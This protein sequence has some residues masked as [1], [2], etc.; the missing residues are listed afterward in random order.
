LPERRIVAQAAVLWLVSRALL[1]L[2]WWVA[3]AFGLVLPNGQT[4]PLSPEVTNAHSS[5]LPWLHWDAVWYVTIA[6]RGYDFQS[7]LAPGGQPVVLPGFFPLYPLLI[8]ALTLVLGARQAVLA[9]LLVSNGAALVA[10]IGLGLLAAHEESRGDGVRAAGRLILVTAAYPFAFFL[11]APYTES[12]FLACLVFS[13]YLARRGVWWG[14]ATCAFL[15]GLTRPTALALVPALAW[16]YG[17]QHGFWEWERWRAAPWRA[18]PAPRVLAQG[19]VVVGAAPLALGT[20]MALLAVRFGDPFLYVESQDQYHGHVHWAIWQTMFELG[21]RLLSLPL[22]TPD[23][24][25]LYV[26]AAA[27]LSFFAVT[28]A[29]LR[30]VPLLYTLYMLATFYLLLT[31]PVPSKPELL[32]SMGRYLLVAVPVFLLL[33]RWIERRPWLESLVIGGGFLLQGVFVVIFFRGIRID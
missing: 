4:G 10:F 13:F 2:L 22:F 27:F 23:K 30:R 11:F 5:L 31:V 9:A 14:A 12:V 25:M 8:H 3:L 18:L 20:Y 21:R 24:T 15:A 17:R 7:Q 6:T 28:V 26:E 32:P 29:G 16:E 19:A 33:A 1:M